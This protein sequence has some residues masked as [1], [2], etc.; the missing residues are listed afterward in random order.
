MAEPLPPITRPDGK[1][2]RPRK[3]I[4]YVLGDE[5]ECPVGVVVFGTHDFERAV[6]LA[7]DLVRQAWGAGYELGDGPL[8]VW[9]KDTYQYGRRIW[10]D[11]KEH[12]RAGVWF[13]EIVEA[14]MPP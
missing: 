11:D 3:V 5:D 1:L 12:G 6:P 10:E 9:W 13:P 14:T 2:Y 8:A 4:A 7:A